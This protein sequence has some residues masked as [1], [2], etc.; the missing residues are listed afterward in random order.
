MKTMTI[1]KVQ[2]KYF[3]WLIGII[4]P[5]SDKELFKYKNLCEV[6]DSIEFRLPSKHDTSDVKRILDAMD[7]R[8]D[9]IGYLASEGVYIPIQDCR[10][11]F[12]NNKP[13]VFEVLISL[14][15][16]IKYNDEYNTSNWFWI[17]IANLRIN[18]IKDD[19]FEKEPKEYK[20]II[21]IVID[22]WMYRKF[23]S[24]GEG[25]LFPLKDTD[26]DQTKLDIWSQMEAYLAERGDYI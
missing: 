14:A 16:Q 10:N 11:M 5:F 20:E 7:I 19:V 4:Y 8:Y 12:K 24:D 17:M 25:S 13:S 15:R 18:L 23:N 9:F 1:K 26:I 21:E 22:R 6:L 3:N 2:E